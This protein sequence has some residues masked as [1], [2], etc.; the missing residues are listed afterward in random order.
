MARVIIADRHELARAGL[1]SVLADQDDI[2][3]IGEATTGPE[4]IALS[5]RLGP[6]LVLMDIDMPDIDGLAA[7]RTI[8][9]AHPS[10]KVIIITMLEDLNCVL[11]ALRAGATGYLL[12]SS[13]R[14]QILSAVRQA[15]DGDM[16]FQS[17]L[18]PQFIERLARAPRPTPDRPTG[19]L[20][21]RER[22]VLSLIAWGQ[23]NSQISGILGISVTT[24][25]GHVERIFAKL[26]V[27]NRTEAAMQAVALGLI[28]AKPR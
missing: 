3:V 15:L 24:V 6:D 10:T 25:K 4:A 19:P 1:L 21:P 27:T 17:W 18:S 26:G 9:E 22:E 8:M 13:T 12:K 5:E 23:T 2:E 20:T 16:R 14:L 7:A 11:E 28:E